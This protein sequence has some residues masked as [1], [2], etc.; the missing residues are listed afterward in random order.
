MAV[1]IAA[2]ILWSHPLWLGLAGAALVH[3]EAPARAEIA[4]VLAG[5]WRGNRILKAAE[6]V[7]EGWVPRALVS[8]TY[9][10]GWAEPDAAIEFAVRHGFPREWFIALAHSAR[11]TEEEAGIVVQRLRQMGVKRL[12]LVTSDYHT[13]RALGCFRRVAPDLE[14]RAIG[15]PDPDFPPQWWRSRQG[16][17]TFL[18][19]WMKMV[20]WRLGI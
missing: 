5:G 7:R 11:S 6:L 14:I 1:L 2:G 9:Y 16:R 20:S 8:G 10:Y 3:N 19:E 18:L 4:V 15:A 17:K 12:L 13:R